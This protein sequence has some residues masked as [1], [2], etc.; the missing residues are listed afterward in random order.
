MVVPRRRRGS[1]C[2]PVPEFTD[3]PRGSFTAAAE[4]KKKSV[5]VS[6]ISFGTRYGTVNVNGLR[7]PVPVDEPSMR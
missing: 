1:C 7:A 4:A 5:P 6:T 3:D 2:Y